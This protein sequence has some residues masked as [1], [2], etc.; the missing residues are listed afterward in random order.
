MAKP[1]RRRKKYESDSNESYDN[2]VQIASKRFTPKS[3][4]SLIPKTEKQKQFFEAYQQDYPVIVQL[5]A[6][7]TG[8]SMCALWAALNECLEEDSCYS[9]VTIIRSAVENAITGISAGNT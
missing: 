4:A 7:G 1:S 6:A 5:G 2:I 8:K 9:S 3:L